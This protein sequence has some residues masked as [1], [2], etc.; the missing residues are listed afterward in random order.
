MPDIP[1]RPVRFEPEGSDKSVRRWLRENP[2]S[3]EIAFCSSYMAL[4]ASEW[5]REG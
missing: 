3:A 1:S 4:S 2:V 5:E